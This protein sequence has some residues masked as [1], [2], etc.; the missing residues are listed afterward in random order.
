MWAYRRPTEEQ[1]DALTWAGG[2]PGSAR[3]GE[4]WLLL[5]LQ[6]TVPGTDGHCTSAIYYPR[7]FHASLSVETTDPISFSSNIEKRP[8]IKHIPQTKINQLHA[9]KR[10]FG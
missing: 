4:H 5:V 7:G 8:W 6:F 2:K 10:A 9:K 1:T 3:K